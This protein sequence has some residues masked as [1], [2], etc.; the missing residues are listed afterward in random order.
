MSESLLI[1]V[2]DR[3]LRTEAEGPGARYA[4]WVQGCPLRC[5]GCC[6]PHMLEF[7]DA[8]FRTVADV[9]EEILSADN[10]E[11]VTYLGG[12]PFS[13]AAALGEL[14]RTI[15]ERAE[16]STMVFSG[17]TLEQL[18]HRED[19]APLLREVDLLVD[20]PFLQEQLVTDRRWIGSANQRTHF[21]TDRYAH[22]ADEPTGWDGGR[23]TVELRIVNGRIQINGF[24]TP[25]LEAL[26]KQL[27]GDLP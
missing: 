20:G 2:A 23:N 8:E 13:Q 4:L 19:A 7:R 21:L 18:Q 17:F 22:L 5:P 27:E 26:V 24:P 1:N 9:A 10:I 16:L 14:S 11:G 3:V 15:R 25:E 6:N 12:E